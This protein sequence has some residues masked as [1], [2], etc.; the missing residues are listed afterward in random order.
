MAEEFS[1]VHHRI[2]DFLSH[3]KAHVFDLDD[4]K[5]KL[6]LSDA[7]FCAEDL[8]R[9]RAFFHAIQQATRDLHREKNEIIAVDAGSGTG[10]LGMF[11]LMAGAQKC[12]F[13]EHN[14]HSLEYSK[15]LL[16]Y[17]GYSHLSEFI[18]CDA[19]TY[20]LREKYDLLISEA[21]TSGFVR[22]DFPPIVDHLRQFGNSASKI[23]PE[24]FEIQIFEKDAIGNILEK[25]HVQFSSQEKFKKQKIQLKSS[26]T[27][28]LSFQTKALL[29]ADISLSS[30]DTMSFLNEQ[31][32]NF[33]TEKHQ[34]FDFS[35]K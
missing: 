29:Y 23:I 12:Y 10:I 7:I 24:S 26:G 34:L 28:S 17:F 20:K 4:A 1:Q 22:E 27:S 30:G 3:S 21:I 11:A 19:T 25:H 18:L 32:F 9:N 2:L 31:N 16:D 35:P 14:P 15:K 13:L 33:R 6:P 5:F 8:L